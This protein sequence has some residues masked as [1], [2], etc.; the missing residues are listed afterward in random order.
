MSWS[1]CFLLERACVRSHMWVKNKQLQTHVRQHEHAPCLEERGGQS[2]KKEVY[3]K[4]TGGHS[5]GPQSCG[6][7]GPLP[8]LY[9]YGPLSVRVEAARL[10]KHELHLLV[11][12]R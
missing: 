12:T 11:R 2:G 8:E 4:R 6:H 1:S 3:L 7:R 5:G 9:E 10:R